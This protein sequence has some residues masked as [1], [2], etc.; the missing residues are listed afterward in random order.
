MA[1]GPAACAWPRYWPS[2]PL[3]I[4]GAAGSGKT[5]LL[6]IVMADLL[7]DPD[8][9]AFAAELA[10]ALPKPLPLPVF[11]PLRSSSSPVPVD[12]AY[13]RTQASLLRF[14]DDW[15]CQG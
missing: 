12:V 5:T 3:A 1:H 6:R 7:T 14:L 8:P 13:Q 10:A 4:V 15:F 9:A 11:M 2:R